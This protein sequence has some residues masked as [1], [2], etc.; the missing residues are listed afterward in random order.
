MVVEAAQGTALRVASGPH[1]HVHGVD[2]RTSSGERMACEQVPQS[3][4]VDS[5][6]I[7]R[8]VEAA[9]ATTVRLLEAQVDG[10]G[11][12]FGGEDGVAELEEGVFPAMEAFVE[13]AAEGA[14]SI[15][16]RFH[17]A[18][19]MHPPRVLRTLCRRWS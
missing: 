15:E 2:G 14:K 11:D 12:G 18:P 17:D 19:I 9:P 1:A 4:D 3:L 5:P 7:Q 16:R 10:R 13:R 8:G 6:A